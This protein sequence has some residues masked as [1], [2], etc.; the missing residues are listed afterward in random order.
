MSQSQPKKRN[1]GSKQNGEIKREGF[2][3]TLDDQTIQLNSN[4]YTAPSKD[5]TKQ[6]C[7][8]HLEYNLDQAGCEPSPNM[9]EQFGDEID[10]NK[11][12]KE[13][14]NSKVNEEN[15]PLPPLSF[16]IVCPVED[17]R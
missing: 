6:K 3:T 2:E 10:K 14:S 16:T 9:Q 8:T 5:M 12:S 15:L 13:S 4:H 11:D 1:Q 7:P 17:C